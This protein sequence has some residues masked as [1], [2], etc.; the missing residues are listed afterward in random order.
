MNSFSSINAT[1]FA[2]FF[3]SCFIPYRIINVSRK[4]ENV[5]NV[6]KV[7]GRPPLSLMCP[8][9]VLLVFLI[10]CFL[11]PTPKHLSKL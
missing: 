11:K 9:G 7:K 5:L 8:E 6:C 4:L 1:G 3:L 10:C 2:Q